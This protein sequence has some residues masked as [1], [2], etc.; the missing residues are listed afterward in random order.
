MY[1]IR[2]HIDTSPYDD[3]GGIEEILGVHHDLTGAYQEADDI[4][5]EIEDQL[6]A[7]GEGHRDFWIELTIRDTT[8]GL[9]VAH[10]GIGLIPAKPRLEQP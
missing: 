1:E 3:P 4:A 9:D 10:I 8:T 2:T 6:L 7:N 5:D